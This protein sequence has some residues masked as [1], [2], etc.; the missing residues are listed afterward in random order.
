METCEKQLLQFLQQLIFSLEVIDFVTKNQLDRN[1]YNKSYF[2][3]SLNPMKK[4]LLLLSSS[5]LV[6]LVFAQNNLIIHMP[7]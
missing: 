2:L 5:L 4:A 6:S 7:E 1:E 3:I